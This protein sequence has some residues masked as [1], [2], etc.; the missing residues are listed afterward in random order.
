[1]ELP[2]GGSEKPVQT[3][4]FLLGMAMAMLSNSRTVHM[5]FSDEWR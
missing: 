1:M 2:P 3:M 4:Q 5:G